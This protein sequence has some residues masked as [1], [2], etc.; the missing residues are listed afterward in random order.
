MRL[1]HAKPF[2]GLVI[3]CGNDFVIQHK[4]V[5]FFVNFGQN[6]RERFADH[7]HDLFALEQL[8]ILLNGKIAVKFTQNILWVGSS[9]FGNVQ[10]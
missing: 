1:K 4:V 5:I 10:I 9:T 6:V 2:L 7:I 8:A 3:V